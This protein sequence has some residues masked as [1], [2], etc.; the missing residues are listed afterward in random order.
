MKRDIINKLLAWKVD[1]YRKPLL[2][3]GV[4]QCGKTYICKKFGKEYFT[5]IVYFDF[6]EREDLKSV[7]ALNLD[8]ERIIR[9]LEVLSGSDKIIPGETLVVFDEIQTAPRAITALKYFCE[10]M[11]Q[12]HIIAAGSLLGLALKREDFSFPVGKV[13]MLQMYPMT[14]KEFL[15]AVGEEGLC[16]GL[17]QYTLGQE[18]PHIYGES[19]ERALKSYYIV[20][21]LPEVVA[22]WVKSKDYEVVDR[23]QTRMI[24][25][26][27][28][29]FA[30]YAPRGEFPKLEMLWRAVPQQL[31]KENNKFVFSHVKEGKRAK[32][33]ED[34]L[35]WLKDAGLIYKLLLVENP[36]LPLA[37]NAKDSYFKVYMFDVGLLRRIANVSPKIILEG[38]ESYKN[39]KGS[40][41][42]NFVL[43]ELIAQGF[44]PYFWRSNNSAEVDFLLEDESRVIPI[45]A[46]AEVST[47]AKSFKL[48]CKKYKIN[49]GFKMSLKNLGKSQE[50]S[51]KVWNL[52][53]YL[54]WQ[55]KEY[56][57]NESE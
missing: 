2:L 42:E 33:L 55:F 39:F 49:L 32:D 37:F 10:K 3:T 51:T 18:F 27:E 31:A 17:K 53:L 19:L 44:K 30:K 21:G 1:E 7:F 6:D 22:A 38:S 13:D 54:I 11:P 40:F 41:T 9:D 47:R 48:F 15:E 16:E 57:K 24:R 8:P 46:K 28:G 35:L 5:N 45:E 4:R 36:E 29:D 56:L 26:Y 14:F 23:L 12:L 34:A 25:E 50:D 43:T 20:G 52:P